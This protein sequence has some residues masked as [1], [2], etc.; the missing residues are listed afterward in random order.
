MKTKN[1]ITSRRK[2]WIVFADCVFGVLLVTCSVL[3]RMMK[4]AQLNKGQ[5]GAGSVL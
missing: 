3:S 4:N 5:I 1:R 2:N